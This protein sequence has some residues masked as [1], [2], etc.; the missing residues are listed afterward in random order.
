MR[1]LSPLEIV[2]EIKMVAQITEKLLTSTRSGDARG[3]EPAAAQYLQAC[4]TK[5]KL[6]DRERRHSRRDKRRTQMDTGAR[7]TSIR[8]GVIHPGYA[9]CVLRRLLG[10]PETQITDAMLESW[11]N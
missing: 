5:L 9:R 11:E 8:A 7:L 3:D 1:E 10:F 6:G 2:N 4:E